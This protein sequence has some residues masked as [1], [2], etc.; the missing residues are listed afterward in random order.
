MRIAAVVNRHSAEKLGGERFL[1]TLHSVFQS[2]HLE[3]SLIAVQPTAVAAKA[4]SFL[5]DKVDA[6]IVGGGDGTISSAAEICARAG[7]PLGIL[8]LGTRNHFARDAGLPLDLIEAVAVIARGRT[9]RVDMGCVEDRRFIN[10]SS[11][12]A[13]PR[14]VEYR[15][16]LR[17]RLGLRKYVAAMF[18]TVRAFTHYPPLK[19]VLVINGRRLSRATPFIFVGNNI[20]SVDL[21]SWQFRKQIDAGKLCVYTASTE[22]LR[23]FLRLFWLSMINRLDQS[24][25]F[26]THIASEFTIHIAKPRVRVANDGEV[27]RFTP[28]LRYRI[29]PNALEIFVP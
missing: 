5:E 24:R 26:E 14:A 10:N 28:P 15:D 17:A 7:R 3:S 13:Y 21:F 27:L 23:G 1:K 2:Q 9:R 4:R 19:A 20:Y 22:G 29:D 11:L 25:D 8:P 16:E 6:L 18:A 12:G